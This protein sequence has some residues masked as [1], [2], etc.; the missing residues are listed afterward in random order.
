M[1]APGAKDM[2][3]AQLNDRIKRRDACANPIRE[4]RNFIST[5]SRA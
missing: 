5:P 4:R 3:A 1:D 2:S